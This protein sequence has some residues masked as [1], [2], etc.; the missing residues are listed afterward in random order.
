VPV[1]K[2]ELAAWR[3]EIVDYRLVI[4]EDMKPDIARAYWAIIEFI[5]ARIKL[6]G[7][8]Y[9]EQMELVDR[10]LEQRFTRRRPGV[11]G[12]RMRSLRAL[13]P[14]SVRHELKRLADLVGTERP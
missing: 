10:E 1:L 12:R 7:A 11:L 6:S 8:N 13:N 2:S 9:E 5:E 14:P 4:T 3:R